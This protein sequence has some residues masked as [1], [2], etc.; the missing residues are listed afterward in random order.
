MSGAP[1]LLGC[2]N[3]GGGL[4]GKECAAVAAVFDE[5]AARGDLD[6]VAARCR[7]TAVAAMGELPEHFTCLG[8]QAGEQVVAVEDEQV[9]VVE[10]E[11]ARRLVVDRVAD[12]RPD[13]IAGL[14]IKGRDGVVFGAAGLDDEQIVVEARGGGKTPG[15]G[16]ALMFCYQVDA[17]ALATVG[18]VEGKEVALGAQ[19]DDL[20]FV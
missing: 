8:G 16:D 4:D 1:G 9:V 7:G 14:R 18:G 12:S 19:G 6:G 5:I 10:A 17:P 15:W 2:V 20:I 11:E 13:E 3:L